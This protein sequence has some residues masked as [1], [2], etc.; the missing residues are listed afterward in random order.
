MTTFTVLLVIVLTGDSG[1]GSL[2]N[3][4]ANLAN[5]ED[6]LF[7]AFIRQGYQPIPAAIHNMIAVYYADLG[8][9]TFVN[10]VLNANG[11][12]VP[13]RCRSKGRKQIGGG[14][15]DDETL[16]TACRIQCSAG[17]FLTKPPSR[18]SSRR[19]PFND[20]LLVG[21]HRNGAL[22]AYTVVHN[23]VS[24][25]KWGS[26]NIHDV[27]SWNKV[28]FNKFK[29]ARMTD[30]RVEHIDVPTKRKHT[31]DCISLAYVQETLHGGFEQTLLGHYR[32]VP[33]VYKRWICPNEGPEPL[34]YKLEISFDYG[35]SYHIIGGFVGF[36][37]NTHR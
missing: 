35:A 7:S 5:P 13:A 28:D 19:S 16:D 23:K 11:L 9:D 2:V 27:H 34:S 15:F 29:C 8:F 21:F 17:S 3:A 30:T 24:D 25:R 33:N 18:N 14:D 32:A 36:R 26:Q 31:T 10:D 20:E 37:D 6:L 22:N 1:L 4:S 12:Q